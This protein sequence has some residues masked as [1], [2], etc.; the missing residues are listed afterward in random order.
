MGDNT[1]EVT[2]T[3]ADGATTAAYTVVVARAQPPTYTVVYGDTLS[4]IARR[5]GISLG[6][7]IAANNIRNPN[8][9]FAGQVLVIPA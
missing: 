2:V 9:I 4:A 1:V 7:L 8:L 6:E 3:A 5:F